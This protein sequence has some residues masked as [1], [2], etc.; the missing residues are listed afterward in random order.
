MMY[1]SAVFAYRLGSIRI[2]DTAPGYQHPAQPRGGAWRG[3][4]RALVVPLH[5]MHLPA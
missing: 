5:R 1:R 3:R 2:R 4:E